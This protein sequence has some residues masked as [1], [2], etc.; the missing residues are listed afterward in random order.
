MIDTVRFKVQLSPKSPADIQAKTG[1]KVSVSTG[2]ETWFSDG[3]HLALQDFTIAQHEASGLRAAWKGASWLEASV[4]V[5]LPRALYG[6]NGQLLQD[7]SDIADALHVVDGL[8]W[9]LGNPCSFTPDWTPAFIPEYNRVDLVWHF[10]GSPASWILA[11]ALGSH[12]WVRKVPQQYFGETLT[13]HGKEVGICIYDK[14]LEQNGKPGNVVRVEVRLKGKRLLTSLGEYWQGDKSRLHVLSLPF[15]RCWQV[16]RSACVAFEPTLLPVIPK[17]RSASPWIAMLISEGATIKGVP[18]ADLVRVQVSRATRYR[19]NALVK[20]YR[21]EYTGIHWSELL[22]EEGPSLVPPEVLP[23]K[24]E[25]PAA[26][27]IA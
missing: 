13:F 5:S 24:K 20:S 7:E 12:P 25:T 19:I 11:H 21:T 8:L 16:Y 4:E 1:W 14:E 10:A 22:P 6:S 2:R 26:V 27:A 15:K 18:L 17:G 9:E 23:L 3:G